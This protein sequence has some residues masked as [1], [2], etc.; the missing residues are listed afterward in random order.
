MK[1]NLPLDAGLTVNEPAPVMLLLI[2][3]NKGLK[4]KVPLLLNVCKVYPL[5]APVPATGLPPVA[6]AE[7]TYRMTTRPDPPA[8]A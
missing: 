6:A 8:P 3:A 7:P 2:V 5:A 1:V 4:A